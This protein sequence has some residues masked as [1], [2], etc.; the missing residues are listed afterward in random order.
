MRPAFWVADYRGL[1]IHDSRMGHWGK[2]QTGFNLSESGRVFLSDGRKIKRDGVWS[3]PCHRDLVNG[4]GPDRTVYSG[5]YSYGYADGPSLWLYPH[6]ERSLNEAMKAGL[7]SLV[8]VHRIDGQTPV[9]SNTSR[10]LLFL[11]QDV[12]ANADSALLA[13]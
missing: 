7:N 1:E 3:Y 11:L 10:E 13:A 8:G 12:G 9:Y 5:I 2:G 6:A 4:H